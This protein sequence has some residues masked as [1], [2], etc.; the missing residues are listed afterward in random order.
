MTVRV[1]CFFEP[2]EKVRQWVGQLIANSYG[3]RLWENNH[4]LGA[5]R[6]A[7]H[8]AAVVLL[9]ELPGSLDRGCVDHWIEHV[10]R[11]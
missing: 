5:I 6:Q 3:A 7:D 11:Q 2:V 1:E 8:I 4:R 9:H 10:R